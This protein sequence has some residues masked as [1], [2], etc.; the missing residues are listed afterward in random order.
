MLLIL[1]YKAETYLTTCAHGD[2]RKEK[3]KREGRE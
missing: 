1:S 3:E 2:R